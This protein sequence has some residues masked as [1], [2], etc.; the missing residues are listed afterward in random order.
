M[1][2]LWVNEEIAIA[3]TLQKIFYTDPI[4]FEAS[5]EKIFANTWQWI[6]PIN[7]NGAAYNCFP[8][9]LLPGYLNEPL[10]IT[11]NASGALQ[12]MSNVCTHRGAL[13]VN[14][15]CT[16]ANIKCPYHGRMFDL[17]G[18]F[19]SMPEFKE[20]KNFP[21]NADHL[22]PLPLQIFAG[23]LFTNL[24][25]NIAFQSFFGPMLQR[26]HWMPMQEFVFQ[27]ELSKDYTVNAHWALYCENY[28]E[29]FHIPFVH[30]ALNEALDFG[31]YRTELYEYSS[32]QLGIAKT[33]DDCFDL[34]NSSADYGEK[35]AAYYYFVFPN[36]MFNFY[37][38]GLSLNVVKPLTPVKTLVSY[39]TFVW[40]P[41]KLQQGAGAN[42]NNT[43]MEDEEIVENV[44]LGIQSRFYNH[45]RYSVKH[46][47]GT[48]HF[49][50]LIA[51]FL[52]D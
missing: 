43:E 48:H 51:Q 7:P 16:Q 47:Q 39:Y 29:G 28:L 8:Y 25:G 38:W 5:K 1:T 33:M 20:V 10:L 36:L 12:C 13:L 40:Q 31:A 15:P 42:V 49:H 32:L 27:P 37:P 18:C 19:K 3:N 34:P 6:A 14:A 2:K 9:T 4:Y 11:K 26:L 46:E 44:Q 30:P 23:N 22:H 35:I 24:I 45:G 50:R 21:S 17:D 41:H 52:Q